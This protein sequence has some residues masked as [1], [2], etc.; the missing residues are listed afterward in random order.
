MKKVVLLLLLIF[1][2][3]ITYPVLG[4][5][6]T[7]LQENTTTEL[8]TSGN[9]H[10]AKKVKSTKPKKKKQTKHK[11]TKKHAPKPAKKKTHKKK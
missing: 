7:K 10:H 5:S 11:K 2:G 3:S 1:I 4:E 9:G 8:A 6:M